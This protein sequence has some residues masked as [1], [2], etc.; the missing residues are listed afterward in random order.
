[1][2]YR[3]GLQLSVFLD[4]LISCVCFFYAKAQRRKGEVENNPSSTGQPGQVVCEFSLYV[5]VSSL[6]LLNR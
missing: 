4:N 6:F 2:P 3:V 1:M 5:V